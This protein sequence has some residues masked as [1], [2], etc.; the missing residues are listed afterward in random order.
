MTTSSVPI[1]SVVLFSIPTLGIIL[2]S[3]LTLSIR[4]KKVYSNLNV[5]V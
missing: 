4:V 5:A 3:I 1:L 2:Y